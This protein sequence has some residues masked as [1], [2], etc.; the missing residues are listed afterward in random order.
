MASPYGTQTP[1]M[2]G[3]AVL[4]FGESGRH[5][6]PSNPVFMTQGGMR[7][8]NAAGV[9]ANAPATGPYAQPAYQNAPRRPHAWTAAGRALAAR[10]QQVYGGDLYGNN[11]ATGGL[12]QG[13]NAGNNGQYNSGITAGA[14]NPAAIAQGVAT[15]GMGGQAPGI[16]VSPAAYNTMNQQYSGLMGQAANTAALDFARNAAFQTADMNLA[17]QRARA[18]AGVGYGNLL[19]RIAEMNTNGANQQDALLQNLLMG[20]VG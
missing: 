9:G 3:Q 4:G 8:G 17:Q 11:A 2:P 16:S 13:G 19:A 7:P 5:Y 15:F 14:G 12:G 1:P 10:E 20:L 6:D 18:D